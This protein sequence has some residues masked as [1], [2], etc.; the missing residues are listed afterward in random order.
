MK[1]NYPICQKLSSIRQ[2][3]KRSKYN[4]L[5]QS[6]QTDWQYLHSLHVLHFFNNIIF[7]FCSQVLKPDA[8][9]NSFGVV[10]G[11]KDTTSLLIQVLII[12]HI[13]FKNVNIFVFAFTY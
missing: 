3:L 7:Y 8:G 9:D 13:L 5:Y 10:N 12:K 4:K 1:K 2:A 11:R 6:I